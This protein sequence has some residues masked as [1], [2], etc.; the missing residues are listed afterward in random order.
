MILL[1]AK[2]HDMLNTQV[3]FL[4]KLKSRITADDA[5][6]MLSEQSFEARELRTLVRTPD[7]FITI[8]PQNNF[9]GI[10]EGITNRMKNELEAQGRSRVRISL[11]SS[12]LPQL[13]QAVTKSTLEHL[14]RTLNNY[15]RTIVGTRTQVAEARR[16]IQNHIKILQNYIKDPNKM[17]NASGEIYNVSELYTQTLEAMN[18]ARTKYKTVLQA[19]RH[20]DFK[21]LAAGLRDWYETYNLEDF[22]FNGQE[23]EKSVRPYCFA[24]TKWLGDKVF[25]DVYDAAYS[26]AQHTRWAERMEAS[27]GRGIVKLPPTAEP[28]AAP[29]E[30]DVALQYQTLDRL[31]K[32]APRAT[33]LQAH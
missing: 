28:Y 29:G 1:A 2:N 11:D 20:D 32:L 30:K 31:Q 13:S 10:I 7:I 9:M 16:M 27:G 17:K 33:Y 24:M 12:F 23:V 15:K 22:L 3:D 14:I 21:I 6:N 5:V 25:G 26:E 18:G 8:T 4:T 19:S